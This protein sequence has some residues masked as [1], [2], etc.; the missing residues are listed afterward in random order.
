MSAPLPRPLYGCSSLAIAD[1]QVEKNA[2]GKVAVSFGLVLGAAA[3][4]IF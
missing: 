3:A 2:A 1:M 4:A